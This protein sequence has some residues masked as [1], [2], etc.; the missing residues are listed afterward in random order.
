MTETRIRC[1]A[2]PNWPD[3]KRRT[4]AE[5]FREEISAYG[6]HL[7]QRLMNA[8][9]LVG[10]AAHKAA[11][12]LTFHKMEGQRR[13]EDQI[14]E[15]AFADMRESIA[16]GLYW[17]D[18]TSNR[19]QAE[20]QTRRIVAVYRQEVLPRI[21]P[22]AVEEELKASLPGG[23][24]LTGRKDILARAPRTLDDLKTGKRRRMAVAQYG[25]YGLLERTHRPEP[26]L[27]ALREHYIARVITSKAQPNAQTLEFPV[28]PAENE[29][30]AIIDDI[31]EAHTKFQRRALVGTE[32]PET[33][34]MANPRSM[35]CSEKYCSAWGTDFCRVHAGAKL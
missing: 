29:A 9:A 10:I 26:E 24:V 15:P 20:K 4:A 2:L 21:E 1:S 33:A 34:F 13:P 12:L 11:A 25:G 32:A 5:L 22:I 35:L 31:R 14:L 8:G 19:D 28:V 27:T 3:C 18:V 6:F 23:Y 16:S 17:D 7:R 30:M